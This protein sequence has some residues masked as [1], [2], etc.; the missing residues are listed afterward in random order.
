MVEAQPNLFRSLMTTQLQL[1]DF[2][3]GPAPAIQQKRKRADKSQVK[4]PRKR[5]RIIEPRPPP[6]PSQPLGNDLLS[7]L[8]ANT[9]LSQ[10]PPPTLAPPPPAAPDPTLIRESMS[11]LIDLSDIATIHYRHYF[12]YRLQPVDNSVLRASLH[13][14]M[15]I[16]ITKAILGGGLR[17]FAAVY[18]AL[19]H[20]TRLIETTVLN[21]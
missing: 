1:N 11:D 15:L 4:V 3:W 21:T 13:L 20:A 9:I 16:S 10:S 8:I 19:A 5:V 7:E 18:S 14:S 6:I 2:R 17:T 12:E